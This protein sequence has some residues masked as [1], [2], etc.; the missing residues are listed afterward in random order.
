MTLSKLKIAVPVQEPG[1]QLACIGHSLSDTQ[2]TVYMIILFKL[3][4]ISY[5]RFQDYSESTIEYL[6]EQSDFF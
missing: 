3:T 6:E 2:L 5:A 1:D 4:T